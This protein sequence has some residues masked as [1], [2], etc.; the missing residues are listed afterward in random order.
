MQM[1][2]YIILA[3]KWFQILII[4][5]HVSL[6]LSLYQ[7]FNK[8]LS[9]HTFATKQCE[10]DIEKGMNNDP[11]KCLDDDRGDVAFVSSK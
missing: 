1:M 4:L 5:W 6:S 7:Y 3:V 11:I 8:Q 9:E 2:I 10:P